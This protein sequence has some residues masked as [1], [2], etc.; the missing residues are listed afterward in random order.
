MNSSAKDDIVKVIDFEGEEWLFYKSFPVDVALIRGT[1]ID[2]NGNLTMENEGIINEGLSVAQAA[3]NSGG[4]VIAQAE[5]LVK[6]GTL[7]PKDVR[8]PGALV[9]YIVI[10]TDKDCC[11]QTEGTYFN[12]VFAGHIKVPTKVLPRLEMGHRKVLLR[13]AAMELRENNLVNLGYGMPVDV[14][15]VIAEEGV[16]EKVKLTTEAGTFSVRAVFQLV[17]D[18]I[19]LTEIAP[20]IDL[21]RDVFRGWI[22]VL[23]WLKI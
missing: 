12:P 16:L 7:N 8:V 15:S 11:W 17:G 3:K 2:E 6:N 18:D 14:A 5:F 4:I 23:W 10:A 19:V 13:R 21:E 1:S 22:F 20:G 9:D